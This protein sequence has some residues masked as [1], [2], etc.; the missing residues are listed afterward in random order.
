MELKS[1]FATFLSDIR[2]TDKQVDDLKMGHETLRERLRND[3]EIKR[4]IVSDFLQGSYRR[5]TAVRPN[6]DKRADVD[7]IIVTNMKEKEYPP[8][9]AMDKFIPFLEKYYKDKY[10]KQGRSFG[11]ELS[12]VDLDLVITSAPSEA[13]KAIYESAAVRTDYDIYKTQD[14]RLNEYWLDIPSRLTANASILLDKAKK[15][16]EWK[17][18]PL[19]IPDREV[20]CWESTH[21]LAQIQWTRDKN[22]RCNNHFVNVVKALKWWRLEN[23]EEPKQPKGYPLERLVGEC[24][25]DDI[26]SVAEGI[27]LTLENIVSQYAVKVCLESKPFLCDYGVP[28][29]DVFKRITSTEFAAFY[30]QAK[31]GAQIARSALDSS[32][33]SE[34]GNL[35]IKLLGKR[36]PKPPDDSGN[37][38]GG[39]TKPDCFAIPMGGRFA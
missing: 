11:I 24:C 38:N 6:G 9:K 15:Q 17:T 13:E 34:S 19:R 32:D 23:Y 12:Y 25:P 39:F 30:E 5:Y 31:E 35:W 37:K 1:D 28:E 14:W 8:T 4:I 20:N 33:R 18:N 7:V 26:N 22:S 27:T 2:L 10:N 21:P 36:F 3:E 29:H 16:E